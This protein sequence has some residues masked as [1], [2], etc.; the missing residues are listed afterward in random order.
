MGRIANILSV[1]FV[2]GTVRVLTDNV[3]RPN[4][5][6]PED[7]FSTRKAMRKEINRSIRAENRRK[8]R[9]AARREELER[10]EVA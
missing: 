7:K 1:E 5:T 2:N 9:R 6:Y 4:F 10:D 3:D 8:D